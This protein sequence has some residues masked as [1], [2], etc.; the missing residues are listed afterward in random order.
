MIKKSMEWQKNN[1]DK[2]RE[3]QRKFY[4]NHRSQRIKEVVQRNKEHP[5]VYGEYQKRYCAERR[6]SDPTFNLNQRMKS[7]INRSLKGNKAG[8]HWEILVGYTVKTLKKCLKRT[9]PSGY[10]WQD[11]LEAKLEID[12]IIPKSAFDFT[13]PEDE[14]FKKCWALNNLQLLTAKA[15][16]LKR[17]KV[18]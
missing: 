9:M 11:Y 4:R 7:A 5:E 14:D 3:H 6:K 2:A 12:H 1:R 10:T 17:D 15:N 8:R 16:S 18:G 13:K